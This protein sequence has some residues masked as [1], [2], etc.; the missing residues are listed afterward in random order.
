[1]GRDMKHDAK[2]RHAESGCGNRQE[3]LDRRVGAADTVLPRGE[4]AGGPFAEQFPLLPVRI[5]TPA[6]APDPRQ[7]V[8]K[9]NGDEDEAAHH[10]EQ[11]IGVAVGG[12]APRRYGEPKRKAGHRDIDERM[13]V[14][15]HRRIARLK[16]GAHGALLEYSRGCQP[17]RPYWLTW[18]VDAALPCGSMPRWCFSA[19]RAERPAKIIIVPAEPRPGR[20]DDVWG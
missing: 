19:D 13:K 9:R 20:N 18:G 4:L 15:R 8:G 6:F 11:I 2:G 17:G 7:N 10:R 5:A 16:Y 3:H 14:I 12:E 1:M